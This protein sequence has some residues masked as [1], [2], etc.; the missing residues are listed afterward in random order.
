MIL[1]I[2]SIQTILLGI[3]LYTIRNQVISSL[4]VIFIIVV[5]TISLIYPISS[6]FVD[7]ISWRNTDLLI[8]E[9]QIISIQILYLTFIL[10]F[11]LSQSIL[12]RLSRAPSI[13]CFS[14]EKT[15]DRD[16]YTNNFTAF[17][18]MLFGIFL[19]APYI[20]SAGSSFFSD[21]L[22]E[23]YS[24]TQGLGI[25][26]FGLEIFIGSVIILIFSKVS[27]LGK[28]MLA[29]I[30]ILTA[31]FA[32]I[33]LRARYEL[34][35][36]LGGLCFIYA[37][38]YQIKLKDINIKYIALGVLLIFILEIF[39]IIR[40]YEAILA[41]ASISDFLYDY[42]KILGGMLGGSEMIHPFISA[43]EIIN[44]NRNI[45]SDEYSISVL[46]INLF[47]DILQ[48][49][50]GYLNE[51]QIFARDNYPQLYARGGGTG[52]SLLASGYLY[53]GGVIGVVFLAFF[54]SIMYFYI[55]KIFASGNYLLLIFAPSLISCTIIADRAG[56]ASSLK[57]LLLIFIFFAISNA[58]KHVVRYL[59]LISNNQLN[60]T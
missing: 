55:D 4:S 8:K 26:S 16:I 1:I 40:E 41:Y 20:I 2:A 11:I 43:S 14:F 58:I 45:I 38:K 48:F 17:I 59:I 24:V 33:I 5:G 9:S 21:N 10:V 35:L 44:A 27:W 13:D 37:F 57:T 34:V 6:S 42:E 19:Y 52:F 12:S 18:M 39:T 15:F 31:A 30:L 36:I 23:K 3:Y 60:N 28:R 51:A 47:P 46:L 50:E 25:L 49:Q 32:L 54:M 7:I 22:A 56:L 53:F 29:L